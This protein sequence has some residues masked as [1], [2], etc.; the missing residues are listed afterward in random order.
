MSTTEQ[1]VTT[2]GEVAATSSSAPQPVVAVRRHTIDIVLV[3]AG[4]VVT[5]VLAV[6]GVL[7]QWG[8][9][10][11]SDHVRTELTAQQIF[12]PNEEA[13]TAE[14]RTDLVG[15]AGQQVS[16][17]D[18][19]KAYA[20]YI[21]GHLEGVADG[22]SYAELGTPERAAKAAVKAAKDSG[23]SEAEVADLQ[24]KASAITGQRDTLFRGETLRGLL[25]TTYAWSTIGQIAGIAAITAFVAAGVMFVLV[26]LGIVHL[27]RAKR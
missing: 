3:A 6:A 8:S 25:L 4:V 16:D 17:G 21:G 19:A 22:Q 7:L 12:F 14:G 11:A 24:A 15:F 27:A 10:F 23:A 9:N 13:L 20:S 18:Q 2:A 1:A 26:V 5:V